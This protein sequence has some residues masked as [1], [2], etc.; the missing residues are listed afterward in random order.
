MVNISAVQNFLNR[1]SESEP[2]KQIFKLKAFIEEELECEKCHIFHV[3]SFL[4][5]AKSIDSE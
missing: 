3:D 1:M 2:F 4:K 5:E